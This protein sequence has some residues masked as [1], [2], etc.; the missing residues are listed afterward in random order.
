MRAKYGTEVRLVSQIAESLAFRGLGALA[1]FLSGLSA[2][3][4]LTW[5]RPTWT[6]AT[7]T[8]LGLTFWL[9]GAAY[10]AA[11]LL[12]PARAY[13]PLWAQWVRWPPVIALVGAAFAWSCFPQRAIWLPGGP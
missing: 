6:G 13:W 7:A 1:Y 4:F 3:F 5:P 9:V 10:L 2:H 11:D 8:V 12:D